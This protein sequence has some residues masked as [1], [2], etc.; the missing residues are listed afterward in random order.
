MVRGVWTSKQKQIMLQHF[1]THI[2]KKIAPK[3]AEC[4][5]FKELHNELFN[6]K[7]WVQIKVFI[8][9]TYRIE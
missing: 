6:Q 7:I 1:K 3:K 5:K 9:N 4:T 2:N 8:Y